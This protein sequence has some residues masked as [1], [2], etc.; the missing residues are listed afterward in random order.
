MFCNNCGAQVP[1]G[2]A[3]CTSC[4]SRMGSSE[5]QAPPQP[6]AAP[7][8]GAS[9]SW[10]AHIGLISLACVLGLAAVAAVVVMSVKL[11]GD[12]DSESPAFAQLHSTLTDSATYGN[13]RTATTQSALES[14]STTDVSGDP[15]DPFAAGLVEDIEGYLAETWWASSGTSIPNPE[16]VAVATGYPKTYNLR[17]G[18]NQYI[19]DAEAQAIQ[20]IEVDSAG[21]ETD[22]GDFPYSVAAQGSLLFSFDRT[23][24]IEGT[25]HH[26]S[27]AFFVCEDVLYEVE[28]MDG[29]E[30]S[31]Y[32][33][34]EI[35][36][37]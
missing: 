22:Q 17:F 10:K 6:S 23:V 32:I 1:E 20:M 37:P 14:S 33:A 28:I 35:Y 2:K 16:A 4:G 12:S 15:Q 11:A 19:F 13:D 31:N 7:A 27:S 8:Q 25:V 30:V 34:Y 36:G 3:F 18:Q 21:I 9:G 26:L 24:T 5:G 29:Q